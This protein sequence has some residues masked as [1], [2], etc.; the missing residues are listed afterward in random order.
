MRCSSAWSDHLW[1]YRDGGP[2]PRSSRSRTCPAQQPPPQA[3]GA[4][5]LPGAGAADRFVISS[6]AS[7]A[8]ADAMVV[9]ASADPV[10]RRN[11]DGEV[12]EVQKLTVNAA[13]TLA[14]VLVM[15]F[16]TA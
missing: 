12:G 6:F 13:A 10:V 2:T 8:R 7:R 1:A 16:A 15:V 4:G 14:A 3:P 11:V 9:V 5:T